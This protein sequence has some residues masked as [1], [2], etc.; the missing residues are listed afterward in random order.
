MPLVSIVAL[1][2]PV[3]EINAA[4]AVSAW[5]KLAKREDELREVV[6]HGFQDGELTLDWLLCSEQIGNL[7]VF[8]L[9]VL[10]G[11]EVDLA[12]SYFA[13]RHAISSA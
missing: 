5:L 3:D 1:E 13:N 2:E 4:N 6:G 12:I 11:D 9:P 8:A 10:F 7:V